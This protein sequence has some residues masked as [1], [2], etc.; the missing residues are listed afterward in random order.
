MQY[1][2]LDKHYNILFEYFNV[3][4]DLSIKFL[5]TWFLITTIF[6]IRVD[7]LNQ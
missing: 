5:E 7:S 4:V 3:Y 1:V 2:Y 6:Q